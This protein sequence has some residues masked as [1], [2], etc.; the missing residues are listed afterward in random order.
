MEIFGI[1]I[2]GTGIK[3]AP[4]DM[5]TGALRSERLRI[6]TPTGAKPRPMA[7]VVAEIVKR[8]DWHGPVGVGFPAVVRSG[9]VRS[10]ANIHQKWIGTQ[11]EA[12]LSESHRLPGMRYQ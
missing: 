3:G 11:I 5:E 10:A 6:P 2:G 4:V 7:E 9:V 8:F 1:D 12:L